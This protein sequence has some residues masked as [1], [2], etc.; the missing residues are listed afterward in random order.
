MI[1]AQCQELSMSTDVFSRS[2]AFDR[3]V[4]ALGPCMNQHLGGRPLHQKRLIV[5]APR[6]H[7]REYLI[8][9]LVPN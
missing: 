4:E 8:S 5:G 7:V 6:I 3:F 1:H 9:H 2:H